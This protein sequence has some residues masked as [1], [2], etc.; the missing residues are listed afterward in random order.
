MRRKQKLTIGAIALLTA[1]LLPACQTPSDRSTTPSS[2][3]TAP[4]QAQTI[5]STSATSELPVAEPYPPRPAQPIDQVESGSDFFEFREQLRQAISDRNADYIRSIADPN[6]KLSFGNPISLDDLDIDNPDAPFWQYLERSLAIGCI[7]TTPGNPP[8]DTSWACPYVFQAPEI[9]DAFEDV[10]IVG[11]GV[12]VHTEANA[13]S[14]VVEVVSN[15]ILKSDSQTLGTLSEAQLRAIETF[16]GWRPVILPE[17][18]RGFVSS[19][20]AYSPIGYRAIFAKVDGAWKMQA[21]VSG[22]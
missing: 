4:S 3:P 7:N 22:D 21:F 5:P 6:I 15:E 17:G 9:T 11:E 1:I 12:E 18:R 2:S 14:P 19:R 10:F 13:S 20:Y 16:E 8:D